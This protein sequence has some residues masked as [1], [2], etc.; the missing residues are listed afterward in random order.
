MLKE[1]NSILRSSLPGT[2]SLRKK[3][4]AAFYPCGMRR[5]L[6]DYFQTE[7]Y[8]IHQSP[9]KWQ[10]LQNVDIFLYA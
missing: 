8:A 3:R 4:A 2:V 10:S 7:Y 9:H 6:P 1:D 5:I